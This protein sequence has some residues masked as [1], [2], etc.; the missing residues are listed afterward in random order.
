LGDSSVERRQGQP[1]VDPA[2]DGIADDAARPGVYDHD[3]VDEADRDGDAGQIPSAN[4]TA[5]RS[6]AWSAARSEQERSAMSLRPEPIGAIPAETVRV[7][8]AAFPK[9]HLGHAA[10]RRV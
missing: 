9:G 3:H 4:C 2:A 8:R 5:T 1:R 7:A 6:G 10:T